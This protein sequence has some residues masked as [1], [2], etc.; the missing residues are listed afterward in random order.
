MNDRFMKLF[1]FLAGTA[2]QLCL[3]SGS[4]LCQIA[5]LYRHDYASA[6]IIGAILLVAYLID[7]KNL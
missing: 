5:C 1:S 6:G 3:I 7:K 2:V 4:C